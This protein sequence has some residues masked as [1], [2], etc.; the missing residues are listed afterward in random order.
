M[1]NLSPSLSESLLNGLYLFFNHNAL[2]LA[3]F[4][5]LIVCASAS[6]RRPSRLA[7]L[8]TFS[9]LILVVGFEYDKNLMEPLRNQTIATVAPAAGT[10][11]KATK[12]VNLVLTD[13]LPVVL[14]VVGWGGL[15][16]ATVVSLFKAPHTKSSSPRS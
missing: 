7:L 5:G 12:L 16:T 3:Y 14:F 4:L 15:L 2:V 13:L 9:F 1:I 8:F 6:F 10:H 11:L